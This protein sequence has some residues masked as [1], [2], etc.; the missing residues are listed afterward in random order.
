MHG[1]NHIKFM[2]AVWSVSPFHYISLY[3]Y[4]LHYICLL[5]LSL[6]IYIYI[7]TFYTEFYENP[8]NG[9]V[10]HTS[11]TDGRMDAVSI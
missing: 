10:A 2:Y 5:H 1:Q 7:K 4:L 11:E 8:S 9:L 6:F 3:L